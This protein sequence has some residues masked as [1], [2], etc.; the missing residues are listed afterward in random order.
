MDEK[1]LIEAGKIAVKA[2]E[3]GIKYIKQGIKYSEIVE[4]VEKLILKEGGQI[5]WVQPS[6]TTTA[7]HF[8]PSFE[9]DP[10]CEEGDLL[11]LDIGVHIDGNIADTSKTKLIGK[12]KDKEKLI[13]VAEEALENALKIIKPGVKLGE[14]GAAQE[15]IAKK[16][17]F[18]TIKNLSG[19]NLDEYKVH[20]G[21]SIPSF[22]NGDERILKENDVIAIEPFITDGEG[23]IKEK[24]ENNVFMY[25]QDKPT[26][27]AF[28]R[29][30][31]PYIKSRKGLPFDRKDI[32]NKFGKAYAKV[33]LK[34]LVKNNIIKGYPPLVE[35]SERP[36]AQAEHSII[37]KE[38]KIIYTKN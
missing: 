14:I 16:Y 10:V 20:G 7:A 19:H 1:K 21:I 37:V 30:I 17:G 3:E 27:N 31:I 33:G 35:V 24:G 8:S 36:V 25:I 38:N 18:T 23:Y 4:F 29:K 9:E 2:R 6:P 11:K 32:E 13:K 12:D 15:E 28:A 34:D 22:N 5:A 26:R